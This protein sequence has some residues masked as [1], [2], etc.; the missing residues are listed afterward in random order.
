MLAILGSQP[1]IDV[2]SPD[3]YTGKRTHMPEYPEE[4]VLRGGHIPTARS[5]P[6][7]KAVDE[8]GRFRSRAELEELY[9][10]LRP[11]DK[12]VVYCRIGERSSHTWFVLTHLLGKPGCATTT[13]RGPNGETP[14]APRSWRA[15]SPV[16]RRREVTAAR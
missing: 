2:R 12:T 10:F 15:R 5:I 3:E 4:G 8:S 11:D 7:A 14:C 9:G 16:R 13:G 1:L 6:W